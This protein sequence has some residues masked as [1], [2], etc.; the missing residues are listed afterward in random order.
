MT[1]LRTL[2]PIRRPMALLLVLALFF[3]ACGL[4]TATDD[5]D[6]LA[7]PLETSE[8]IVI[9]TTGAPQAAPTPL[10]VPEESLTS[11]PAVEPTA[12]ATPI[13]TATDPDASS[14]AVPTS[15]PSPIA[16][17]A[18]AATVT[19]TPTAVVAALSAQT[20]NPSPTPTSAAKA[21]AALSPSRI[22]PVSVACAITPL[23]PVAVG[24]TLQFKAS[25]SPANRAISYTFD[26]G[27]GT[28]D[29]GA[30]SDA[31]YQAPGS[32]RVTLRWRDGTITGTVFCGTVTVK[33]HG[34]NPYGIT[35]S[36]APQRSI[37]VGEIITITAV[38]QHRT[39]APTH[40]EVHHGDGTIDPGYVSRA[41][42]E[43]PGTYSPKAVWRHGNDTGSVSCGNVKVKGNANPFGISCSIAPARPVSV[44]ENLTFTALQLWQS[45][46][47]LH[48]EFDHGD[49]TIDPGGISQAYY[50][51]PGTYTVKLHWKLN[52]NGTKRAELSGTVRCGT[53]TVKADNTNPYGITCGYKPQRPIKVGE[54]ITITA[55]QHNPSFAPIHVE[56]HHGDGT[57]DPGTVSQAYYQ[58]PGTYSPK[59]F[60]RDGNITGSVPCGAVT[61]KPGVYPT[62]T[63][64]PWPNPGVGCTISPLRTVIVGEILTYTAT[65]QTNR[66]VQFAFDHGD[67]TI[68]TTSVSTA[69]Y[70]APGSYTVTLTWADGNQTGTVYCGTVTV[71]PAA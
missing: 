19:A 33:A 54:I 55:V 8:P 38:Q 53:V 16:T 48:F 20:T 6:R 46:V 28:L 71:T 11:T 65:K 5:G 43:S 34:N 29:P 44:G 41:Y 47:A 61:V 23:R 24:E 63:P 9:P 31:Y 56:I 36:Y 1:A 22:V 21:D 52:A 35:C 64:T 17:S 12:T 66:A 26:H 25:H 49:G 3:T 32:Y 7:F 58:S 15:T 62:P 42:Y 30:V 27:D 67:G 37:K 18:P 50:Q 40:I 13:R 39:V 69:Y 68:D 10:A 51:A 4:G 59:A 14:S 60:W 70:E 2:N 57:I 45:P